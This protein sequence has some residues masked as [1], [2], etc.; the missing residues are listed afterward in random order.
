MAAVTVAVLAS[1]SSRGHA[2]GG[3]SP[4]VPASADGGGSG[5]G[6]FVPDA[7]ASPVT[8]PDVTGLPSVVSVAF[9]GGGVVP[10]GGGVPGVSAGGLGASGAGRLF[11]DADSR[12]FSSLEHAAAPTARA[13]TRPRVRTA[14]DAPTVM[15][16]R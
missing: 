13:A 3:A 16:A 9:G 2:G 7:G 8:G 1:V 15:P 6:C 5:D 12:S 10:A 11:R 4:G 14:A